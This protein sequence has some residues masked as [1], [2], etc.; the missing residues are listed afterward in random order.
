MGFDDP[1]CIPTITP[2]AGVCCMLSTPTA[3]NSSAQRRAAHAGYVIAPR[4]VY[5]EEVLLN[6]PTR[7]T[8]RSSGATLLFYA[9]APTRYESNPFGVNRS[10][11]PHDPACAA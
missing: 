3:L 2:V 1:D 8:D 6:H 9:S 11:G 4:F 5:L 7:T 10:R